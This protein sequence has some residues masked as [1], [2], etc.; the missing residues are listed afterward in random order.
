MNTQE[1][2]LYLPVEITERELFSK[3]LIAMETVSRGWSCIIGTKKSLQSSEMSVAGGVVLLK[4][5]I[6]SESKI[7]NFFRSKGVL[8]SSLDEE[9]ITH[10]NMEVITTE[11]YSASTIEMSDVVFLWGDELKNLL[12]KKYPNHK[13][14]F[15]STGNPRVDLWRQEFSSLYDSSVQDIKDKYGDY[16]LICSNFGIYN[17]YLGEDGYLNI[18]KQ[19][20]ILKSEKDYKFYKGV[21]D[22]NRIIFEHFIEILPDLSRRYSD[23]NIIVR[24]HPS[25]NHQ[26]W[27]DAVNGLDNVEVVFE[28]S[29]TPWLIGARAVLHNG[30]TTGLEAHLLKQPVI[31]YRP[32]QS[33]TMEIDIP[34]SVSANAFSKE[35]LFKCIELAIKDPD[36]FEKNF[37]DISE[38]HE[39]LKTIISAIEGPF[40]YTR[41]IDQIEKLYGENNKREKT[42]IEYEDT[43][44]TF[45][46]ILKNVILSFLSNKKY[47]APFLPGF[48]N[49]RV[50]EYNYGK[51]KTKSIGKEDVQSIVNKLK[52]YFPGSSFIV[53][54]YSGSNVAIWLEEKPS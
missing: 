26:A 13:N 38:N 34:N 17:H 22:F 36:A 23:I 33:D 3:T 11:R 24:P 9:G 50:K 39:K 44:K 40:A 10:V 18:L 45:K 41:I 42:P 16:I 7:I 37:P 14:K 12:L 49:D 53:E 52:Q 54:E 25:E 1:K 29:V 51:H 21:W 5:I 48:L 6:P 4:S 15:I 43:S 35:E 31:A 27:H 8:V 28:G 30:C 46:L 2:Y 47:L 20:M 32:V 19:D